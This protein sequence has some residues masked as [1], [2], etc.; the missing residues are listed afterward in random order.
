MSDDMLIALDAAGK[1]TP[2]QRRVLNMPEEAD[3]SWPQYNARGQLR[4]SAA[5]DGS[6]QR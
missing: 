4:G 5:V 1:L 2:R 6:A 3:G